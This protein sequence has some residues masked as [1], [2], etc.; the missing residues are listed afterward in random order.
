MARRLSIP[1]KEL[2]LVIVGPK[3]Y[4]KASRVQRVSVNADLP[5]TIV[6]EVG[7]ASHAGESKDSPNVTLSFS[8]FDVGIEIFSV[9]TGTD[10]AAYPAGGVDIANLS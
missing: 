2:Q 7:S 1:S 5:S 8:A 3:N 9:L 10:P 4:F 6:D